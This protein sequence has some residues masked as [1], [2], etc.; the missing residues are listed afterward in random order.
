LAKHVSMS[1]GIDMSSKRKCYNLCKFIE[2][3][4]DNRMFGQYI[5]KKTKGRKRWISIFCITLIR[6]KEW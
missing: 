2:K 3:H 6:R 1:D 4:V 5:R